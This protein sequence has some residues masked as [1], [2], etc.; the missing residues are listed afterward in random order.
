MTPC[1][2]RR[3]PG[4]ARTPTTTRSTPSSALPVDFSVQDG[5][6]TPTSST[7]MLG[8][9]RR[10]R[11]ALHPGL[12][13]RE[14]PAL[15]RRG[16]GALRGPDRLPRG[17]HGRA[18]PDAGRLPTG[19]WRNAVWNGRL[20]AVPWPTDGPFPWALFYRKDILDK[21][22]ADL[23]ED[24]S[25]SCTRS[26]R[27]SPTRPRACG[28]STT[29]SRWCRCSPRAR[30]P[31]AAGARRRRQGG[32]QVRDAG[33]QGGRGVHG[34]AV[35]KDGLVHP[36]IVATQG[37]RRQAAV[38]RR[39]DRVHA[40]TASAP[41]R[42][43]RPSRPKVD[44]GLQHAAGAALRRRGGDPLVL[45]QRPARSS[46]P[47]SRRASARTGSRSCCGVLNWCAAPFGTKEWELREYGEEGM[48]FTRD[49]D[50][51][52]P[53]PSWRRRRSPTSTASSSAGRR[54][55][56][57]DPRRPTTS[58]T[59]SRTGQRHGEVP[60]EGPLGRASS[61]RC[62]PSTPRSARPTED[63]I[64]DILRGRRPMSDLD[65]IVNEW[66][67]D[68]GDEA[69]RLLAKASRTTAG[70]ERSDDT[71][72]DS[73]DRRTPTLAAAADPLAP[74]R[75]RRLA[76]GRP[77]RRQSLRD[78]LRRDWPLLVMTLP[79]RRAAA[80]LPLPADARQRHRVP[81]LQPVRRRQPVAGVRPQR[82]DRL[83]QLRGAVHR[84][85]VLGR[86][87]EHPVHHRRSSWCSSSR[88]RSRW[89]MLLNSVLSQ[90]AA[91]VRP[92][93]GLPAALLLLGAGGHVLPAD[94][95]RRR[96]ARQRRCA[97]TGWSRGTS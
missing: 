21:A 37:R 49:A 33:V 97:S 93:R 51:C 18:V 24:A 87:A 44:A 52:P 16:Q 39:Q 40:R 76:P 73:A 54:A 46:S 60:G 71:V 77:R 88:C 48:H 47:S 66:R 19:A 29:S 63:K 85:G 17:R 75:R 20:A 84:P 74:R 58:R 89:R 26:A 61:W 79:A 3:R 72:A 45:G 96:A 42:A 57:A 86:G 91:R 6:T 5:N 62:R 83:R 25:T 68:G 23:P 34:Q 59:C 38:Q 36:D 22:G 14:D 82:V 30:L 2:A 53:A 56:V 10:A 32:V 70:H 50:G 13:D 65:A 92:G 15:R 8:A 7:P 11:P 1:G 80:G 12:G 41:G 27:R 55:I 28:R 9:R 67:A 4:W 81:G 94:A 69:P 95:R 78:R 64:T 43:C 35:A 90:P 31:G